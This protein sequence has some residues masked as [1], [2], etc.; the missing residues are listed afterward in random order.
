MKRVICSIH[1]SKAEAWLLPMFFQAPAQAVRV[2]T[3]AVNTQEGDIK[4]HPEDYTLFKIGYFDELS[5]EIESCVPEVLGNGA[6]FKN[7]DVRS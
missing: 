5:G 2:F 4:N 1:D 3:D 7:G 6:N